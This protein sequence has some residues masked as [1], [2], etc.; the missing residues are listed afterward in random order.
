MMWVEPKRETTTNSPTTTISTKSTRKI[1]RLKLRRNV[2]L[3]RKK[4]ERTKHKKKKNKKK[5]INSHICFHTIRLGPY[6]MKC[7]HVRAIKINY[8]LRTV[9]RTQFVLKYN[10]WF[11]L[12]LFCRKYVNRQ[13]HIRKRKTLVKLSEK[14]C[15]INCAKSLVCVWYRVLFVVVA[16]AAVIIDHTHANRA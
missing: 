6:W 13:S 5:E 11:F 9:D 16:A 1:N 12:H 10:V 14:E 8:I 3:I 4:N 2:Y 7:T 15:V